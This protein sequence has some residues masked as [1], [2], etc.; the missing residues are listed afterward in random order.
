MDGNFMNFTD[1]TNLMLKLPNRWFSAAQ[2]EMLKNKSLD[3][4]ELTQLLRD[5][6]D[7]AA[8]LGRSVKKSNPS[9]IQSLSILCDGLINKFEKPG[10]SAIL[11]KWVANHTDSQDQGSVIKLRGAYP[12]IHRLFD[13]FA[14]V[15]KVSVDPAHIDA[16]SFDFINK[17]VQAFPAGVK[18]NENSQAKKSLLDATLTSSLIDFGW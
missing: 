17:Q 2:N 15:K 13:A 12:A 11:A 8:Y 10:K 3:P 1:S 9:E 4:G 16:L 18:Q 7:V 6:E 5:T 14:A